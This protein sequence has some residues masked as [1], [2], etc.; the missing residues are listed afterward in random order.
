KK[1]IFTGAVVDCRTNSPVEGA[2][3]EMKDI[4]GK[5]LQSITKADGTY[6]FDISGEVNMENISISKE[7]YNGVNNKISI[8]KNDESNWQMDVLTNNTI[9]LDKKL[10][11]TPET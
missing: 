4:H 11:I 2:S 7:L 8:S 1:K 6:E 5:T 9:C 3:I 10:V